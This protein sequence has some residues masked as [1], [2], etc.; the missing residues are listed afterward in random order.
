MPK[1]TDLS[2]TNCDNILRANAKF[3]PVCGTKK[4]VLEST[5]KKKKTSKSRTKKEQNEDD[6]KHPADV[7][8][9]A[10]MPESPPFAGLESVNFNLLP[11]MLTRHHDELVKTRRRENFGHW[12][13]IG[14]SVYS[15]DG[16]LRNLCLALLQTF[17]NFHHANESSNELVFGLISKG[18]KIKQVHFDY[19]L[20]ST[21]TFIK[22]YKNKSKVIDGLISR[23]IGNK[24]IL[25]KLKKRIDEGTF[26]S[27]KQIRYFQFCSMEIEKQKIFN[28]G[29][30]PPGWLPDDT[31]MLIQTVQAELAKTK[32]SQSNMNVLFGA[33]ILY[34]LGRDIMD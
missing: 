27:H 15:S 32:G 4:E 33:G 20:G 17:S 34:G 30:V 8:L 23:K 28:S 10:F 22:N 11:D 12:N 7:Q 31:D 2:C 13:I 21:L 3:C 9:K 18:E 16:Q 25:T 24:E 6:S 5:T 29:K 19:L 14:K 26:L 1:L